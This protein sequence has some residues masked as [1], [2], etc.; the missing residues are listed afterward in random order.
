MAQV[1]S[2]VLPLDAAAPGA[3]D[4]AVVVTLREGVTVTASDLQIGAVEIKDADAATRMNLGAGVKA[5]AVRVALSSDD[6]VVGALTETAPATD[7]ASSGLN[8]RLQRIAQRI[9]SLIAL[10]PASLGQKAMAA[11]LAVVVASDQSAIPVSHALLTNQDAGEYET[12]AASQTAQV[13]GATG[14]IGDYLEALIIVPATVNAG[15]VLLLDNATSI[16]IFVGGTA[17]LNELRPV[18]VPF[19]MKSVSGAWKITTGA[20]VSVIGVGNFT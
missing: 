6:L 18:Y 12:V 15:Q 1:M 13:L 10:I 4:P 8:G 9:T 3:T 20:D 2:S 16:T 14:A 5:N 11:S 7:T 17:C 19:K